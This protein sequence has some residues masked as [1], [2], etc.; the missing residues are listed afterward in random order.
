MT[1]K[2]K[3]RST[4]IRNEIGDITIDLTEIKRIIME[5]Y[6]QLNANKLHNLDEMD[7]F[8]ERHKLLKLIQEVNRNLNRH[9]TTQE[10]ELVIK[11]YPQ[12]RA[13]TQM[14]SLMNLTR[15]SKN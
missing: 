10:I 6:E 5:Y 8:L 15:H 4:K 14:A 12:R 3:T 9:R 7:K 11:D 1:K 2:E 13:Q